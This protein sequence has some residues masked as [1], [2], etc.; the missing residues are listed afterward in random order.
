MNSLGK[1]QT[2]V[3]YILSEIFDNPKYYGA[4]AKEIAIAELMFNTQI[5]HAHCEGAISGHL[6]LGI[7]P[8]QYLEENY[9]K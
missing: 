9:G 7:T 8:K 5:A 4:Y 1:K 6:N 3:E 2:A